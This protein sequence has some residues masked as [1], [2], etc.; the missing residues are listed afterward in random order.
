MNGSSLKNGIIIIDEVAHAWPLP[1][2]SVSAGQ[3]KWTAQC[4]AKSTLNIY[5]IKKFTVI[6]SC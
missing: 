3:A 2:K 5:S 6:C 4:Q 1:H